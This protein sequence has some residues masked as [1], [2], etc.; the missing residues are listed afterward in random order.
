MSKALDGADSEDGDTVIVH[1]LDHNRIL[2]RVMGDVDGDS[3][4]NVRERLIEQLTWTPDVI[5]VDLSGVTRIDADGVEGLI[6]A[7]ALAGEP[8]I[9][10]FLVAPPGGAVQTALATAEVTELFEIFSTLSQALGE[11]G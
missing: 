10:L 1:R 2:I 5:L 6:A 4:T 7:A 11:A 9:G 8:D 3:S